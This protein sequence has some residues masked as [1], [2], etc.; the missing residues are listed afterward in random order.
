MG[1]RGLATY[2]LYRFSYL[3]LQ[4]FKSTLQLI[5]WSRKENSEIKKA[6]SY[7]ML[8]SLPA[9][10]LA[11]FFFRP[12][13]SDSLVVRQ[14]FFSTEL[15][16]VIEYFKSISY[17]PSLMVDAG[18]NIGAASRFIQ[19]NFPEIK[20]IIIEP[21][22]EN[23]RMINMNLKEIDYQLY[24]NA[25]WYRTEVLAIDDTKDAWGIR[26]SSFS[27]KGKLVEAMP[28]QIILNQA[29]WGLPDFLKIDIEGAEEEI[30]QKDPDLIN[31]LKRVRCVSVEP[32]SIRGDKL[33]RN[34]LSESGFSVEHHGE[35][36]YGFR[37]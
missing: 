7:L 20:T 4:N 29:G 9:F 15:K 10:P 31:I 17:V 22:E 21:S 34:V 24:P 33:I 23:C 11:I 25:L 32:H 28:L 12:F 18:G 16:P 35:L 5:E 27:G 26:V 8:E 19:L 6:K 37:Y 2:L 1:L 14:H 3:N 13:S 30:F 36:I